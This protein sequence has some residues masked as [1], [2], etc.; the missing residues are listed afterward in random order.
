MSKLPCRF[1]QPLFEEWYIL[2]TKILF[3]QLISVFERDFCELRA[4]NLGWLVKTASYMCRKKFWHE[5]IFLRGCSCL[6]LNSEIVP[7]LFEL[8]LPLLSSKYL[9]TAFLCQWQCSKYTNTFWQKF[10]GPYFFLTADKNCLVFCQKRLR[11]VV[12][13]SFHLSKETLEAVIFLKEIFNRII[14]EVWAENFLMFVKILFIKVRWNFPKR[15]LLCLWNF[16][17]VLSEIEKQFAHFS[18]RKIAGL[19]NFHTTFH[20]VFLKERGCQKLYKFC[21][22]Y[23][24]QNC[25]TNFGQTISGNVFGISL[26]K[27]FEKIWAY[28]FQ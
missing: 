11:K 6:K 4:K 17:P 22:S 8:S 12:K 9:E 5:A 24:S 15:I 16:L 3:L 23:F 25:M 13:T 18:G 14:I 1:S 21:F 20:T 27:Y 2:G 7:K 28:S 10:I 26:Y 19:S